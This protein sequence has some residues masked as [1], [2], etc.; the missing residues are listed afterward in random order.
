MANDGNFFK[1][2]SYIGKSIYGDRDTV[3]VEVPSHSRY[4][5]VKTGRKAS[6]LSKNRKEFEILNRRFEEAKRSIE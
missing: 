4:I 1:Y 6:N 2:P 3:V 5:P